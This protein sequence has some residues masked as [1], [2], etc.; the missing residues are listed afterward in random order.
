M[1]LDHPIR[2]VTDTAMTAA[3]YTPL[4]TQTAIA[5][6]INA[7]PTLVSNPNHGALLNLGTGLIANNGTVTTQTYY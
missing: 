5:N 6:A 3:T 1:A 2:L 7:L 4:E